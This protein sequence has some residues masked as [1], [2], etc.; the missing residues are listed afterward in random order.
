MTEN[1]SLECLHDTAIFF[2]F[3]NHSFSLSHCFCLPS[4]ALLLLRLTEQLFLIS[5]SAIV[6]VKGSRWSLLCVF[7]N[8]LKGFAK[9][10]RRIAFYLAQIEASFEPL[11]V[12]GIGHFE[13][14]FP[15]HAGDR[16]KKRRRNFLLT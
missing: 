15:V 16:R 2:S 4:S 5:A 13:I 10:T 7:Y 11:P 14:A 6:V 3:F 9:K 1:N 12:A 8:R